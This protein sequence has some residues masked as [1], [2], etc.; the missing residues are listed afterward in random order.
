[1]TAS[2]KKTLPWGVTARQDRRSHTAFG[3]ITPALYSLW[4]G[5]L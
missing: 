2:G 4:T 5:T 1:M 3:E